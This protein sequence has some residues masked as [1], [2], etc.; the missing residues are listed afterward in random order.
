VQ[1]WSLLATISWPRTSRL[2]WIFSILHYSFCMRAYAVLHVWLIFLYGGILWFHY[3]H[4][5]S[6]TNYKH[7][8]RTKINFYVPFTDSD[9]LTTCIN[10]DEFEKYPLISYLIVFWFFSEKNCL[11]IQLFFIH[12]PKKNYFS[13]TFL[14]KN[15]FSFTCRRFKSDQ[16]LFRLLVILY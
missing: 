16:T 6:F 8:T 1:T 14:E 13:F 10:L 12:F 7:V 9:T 5:T 11:L 3:P 4:I 2:V 15:Y